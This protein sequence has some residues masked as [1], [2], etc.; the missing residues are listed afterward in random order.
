MLN[1]EV[2][3][4]GI[5]FNGGVLYLDTFERLLDFMCRTFRA[6]RGTKVCA[7][8]SSIAKCTV[9]PGQ[10]GSQT[11]IKKTKKPPHLE[12]LYQPESSC[13]CCEN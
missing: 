4:F 7:A 10:K 11:A 2:R 13:M 6:E 8:K 9:F 5:Q 3:I 12:R 1:F